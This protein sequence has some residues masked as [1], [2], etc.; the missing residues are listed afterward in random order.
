MF[1]I[2]LSEADYFDAE[3]EAHVELYQSIHR[4]TTTIHSHDFFEFVLVVT[5]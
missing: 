5:L 2:R 3:T 1:P 4:V